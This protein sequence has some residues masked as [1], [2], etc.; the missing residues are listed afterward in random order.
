MLTLDLFR[1]NTRL[2]VLAVAIGICVA[3]IVGSFAFTNG[4]NLT[5]RNITTKFQSEGAIGYKGDN[6]SS[7]LV[8]LS[9]THFGNNRFIS[10]SLC[11]AEVNNTTS[12]FFAVDDPHS[13]LQQDLQPPPGEMYSARILPLSGQQTISSSYGS[14]TVFANH[15]YSSSLF[16]AYWYLLDWDDIAKLRPELE[17]NASFIIF[18]TVNDAVRSDM[19]SQGFHYEEMTGILGYFSGGAAEVTNDLWLIIIPASFIVAMLVYSAISMETK[20][21]AREI[22]I[23]K[24]MGASNWQIG[25]IFMFQAIMLSILGAAVGIVIGIIISYAISTSSSFVIE[26][27]LFSLRVT[28]YSMLIA[29]LA[30]VAAGILGAI[31]PT[32]RA[33]HRSVRK[34]M[35]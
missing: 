25:R 2:K 32:Y 35:K 12:T 14:I 19:H 18:L 6:L 1:F 9:T 22:A 11:T 34:A 30:S 5:V 16:P 17:G 20:D 8:D 10:V 26:N 27:S 3:F 15:T 4:L 33:S 24:A 28:E 21:R 29:F 23:L 13:L 31:W 7:S